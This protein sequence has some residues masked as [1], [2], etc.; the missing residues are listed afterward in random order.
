MLLQDIAS[1]SLNVVRGTSND[2]EKEK[3]G[4]KGGTMKGWAKYQYKNITLMRAKD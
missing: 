2:G 3:K 1:L 4:T